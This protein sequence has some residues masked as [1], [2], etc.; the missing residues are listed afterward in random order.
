MKMRG[1]EGMV[2][3]YIFSLLLRG[4]FIFYDFAVCCI[5]VCLLV[6]NSHFQLKLFVNSSISFVSSDT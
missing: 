4:S 2:R 5:F 3:E 6:F 1:R